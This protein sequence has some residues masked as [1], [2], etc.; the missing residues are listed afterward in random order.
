[1][2]EKRT[3]KSWASEQVHKRTDKISNFDKLKAPYII[4]KYITW[5][6][7]Y[8]AVGIEPPVAK[9]KPKPKNNKTERTLDDVATDLDKWQNDIDYANMRMDAYPTNSAEYKE[10]KDIY[11]T[12]LPKVNQLKAEAQT[13]QLGK[14]KTTVEDSI[15]KKEEELKKAKDS[16]KPTSSIETELNALKDKKQNLDVS[17]GT[18]ETK[19]APVGKT[20]TKAAS[21]AALGLPTSALTKPTT[22][23]TKTSTTGGGG[24]SGTGGVGGAGKTGGA[25][26]TGGSNKPPKV[27]DKTKAE[28][29]ADALA[30]AANL[31]LPETLFKYV[32]SLTE[33]GRAHV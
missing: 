6:D 20:Q 19:A 16:D 24:V 8:D 11:D 3:L 14:Q 7:L 33:I 21:A 32:P 9:E 23:A 15:A 25:G 30:A 31:E 26:G 1:M 29:E 17:I 18:A 2:A 12:A 5:G 27:P 10:A 4:S 28:L 13:F 22:P